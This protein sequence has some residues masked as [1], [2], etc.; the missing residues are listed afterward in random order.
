MKKGHKIGL[1]FGS[2]AAR[3]FSQIGI[4]K[5]FTE[6]EIPIDLIA[7]TSVGAIIGAAY[8]KHIKRKD[9]HHAYSKGGWKELF[10]T[11]DLDR[12]FK[13]FAEEKKINKWL[14]DT[15]GNVSFGDLHIPLSIVAADALT[16]EQ[17][18]IKD[19]SVLKAVKAS[20]S[21]PV[22]FP[23]VQIK[24]RLLV[25]GSFVNPIPVDA[26]KEMGATL[27]VAC[28]MTRSGKKEEGNK[29]HMRNAASMKKTLK[30]LLDN[31]GSNVH[32]SRKNINRDFLR[33]L[34]T[35]KQTLDSSESKVV[36]EQLRKADIVITPDVGH[37][38]ILDFAHGKESVMEGYAA[39]KKILPE[40][41]SAMEAFKTEHKERILS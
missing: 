14:E 21:L 33:M 5:A 12:M 9:F 18:V 22:L 28:D 35:M 20:I 26:A 15:I 30:K 36:Q 34:R 1:V 13:G 8:A 2:G 38:D 10:E 4:L 17:V 29:N 39:A 23:P 27:L 32:E 19:G 24:D 31:A 25:D 11:E 40:I 7:G 37:I 16:G 3:G 6:R 41:F